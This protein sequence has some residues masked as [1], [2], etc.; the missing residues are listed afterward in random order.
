MYAYSLTRFLEERVVQYETG[1]PEYLTGKVTADSK[2]VFSNCI[3]SQ[4]RLLNLHVYPA[5]SPVAGSSQDLVQ[6]D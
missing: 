2:F 6:P 4:T 5:P 1:Q 3:A